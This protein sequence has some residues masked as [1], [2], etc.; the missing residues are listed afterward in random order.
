MALVDL[1]FAAFQRNPDLATVFVNEQ[2]RLLIQRKGQSICPYDEFL[3]LAMHIIREGV[4][5][6][7]FRGDIDLNLLRHF[8]LGG[9]RSLL[10]LWAEQ[11]SAYPLENIRANVK[12][13]IMHGL[14]GE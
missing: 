12:Q 5:S 2:H 14:A 6:K 4:R 7:S 10:R 11:P 3:E 9:L 1:V 8:I 13:L